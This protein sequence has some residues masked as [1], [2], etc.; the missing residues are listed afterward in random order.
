MSTV[1]VGT[2]SPPE[3]ATRKNFGLRRVEIPARST[4][5]ARY[6][7]AEH[8]SAQ[9]Q[10]R[11]P[12]LVQ[13]TAYYNDRQPP[14]RVLSRRV[15]PTLQRVRLSAIYTGL[16]HGS[17][18]RQYAEVRVFAYAGDA[19]YGSPDL[20]NHRTLLC[21]IRQRQQPPHPEGT[22]NLHCSWA[23][24]PRVSVLEPALRYSPHASG[25]ARCCA[26]TSM[27]SLAA[28]LEPNVLENYAGCRRS[29]NGTR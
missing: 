26:A 12:L 29:G 18:T 17:W 15:A 23:H 10:A 11:L 5:D 4:Y 8:R 20:R 14:R 27:W 28:N 7:K 9:P 3:A 6:L 21:R 1:P 19:A 2:R 13:F 25:V 24:T 16:S 22:P